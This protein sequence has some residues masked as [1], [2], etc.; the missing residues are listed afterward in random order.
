MFRFAFRVKCAFQQKKSN[1]EKIG[2]KNP[3]MMI[4]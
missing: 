3:P 2:K 4:L 1:K